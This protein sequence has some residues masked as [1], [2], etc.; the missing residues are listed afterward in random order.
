MDGHM[1]IRPAGVR[2]PITIVVVLVGL[3]LTGLVGG[4]ISSRNEQAATEWLD[5]RAEVVF[6]STTA[7]LEETVATLQAVAAFVREAPN[8]DQE[9]FSRFITALQPGDELVGIAYMPIVQHAERDSFEAEMRETIPGFMINELTGGEPIPVPVR[10]EYYPVQF[11]HPGTFF[12]LA[13]QASAD[14][15]IGYAFGF[16]SGS[17]PSYSP[18]RGTTEPSTEPTVSDLAII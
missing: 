5:E 3:V 17:D 10:D 11:W 8:L 18:L 15:E 13:A 16:D 2:D 12:L 4:V 1:G 6:E 7:T 9:S 14:I